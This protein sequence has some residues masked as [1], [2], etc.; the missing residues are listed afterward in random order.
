MTAASYYA[1]KNVVH[2][3]GT[4]VFQTHEDQENERLVATII[5]GAWA[6]ELRSFGA[7][8]PIDWFAVRDGRVVGVLELKSRQHT[9]DKF[10]TVFLNVRK[11]LAL[12]LAEA[13]IGV[14][15]IF[16]VKFTDKIMWVPV[17]D[18]EASR[19]RIGG[20]TRKV[21]SNSDVE[22]VIEVPVSI[23]RPFPA[24]AA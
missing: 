4:N 16:A 17:H 19:L 14:P 11:W 20:C 1:R 2:L 10:A 9:S 24:G 7:L 5:E 13:G 8:S 3:D 22:P 21:K 18:I 12:M 6:C 15:S 23:M